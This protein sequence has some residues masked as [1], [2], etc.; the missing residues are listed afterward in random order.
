MR[1]IKIIKQ[2]LQFQ[3]APFG[4]LSKAHIDSIQCMCTNLCVCVCCTQGCVYVVCVCGVCVCLCVSVCLCSYESEKSPSDIIPKMLA[5]LLWG[6][7]SLRCPGNCQFKWGWVLSEHL[8][9][10]YLH[11]PQW[12]YK[13][14][15]WPP[16]FLHELWRCTVG[17]HDFAESF[18]LTEVSPQPS[19]SLHIDSI[20]SPR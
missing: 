6:T 12:D 1:N 4:F 14:G 18:F 19:Q 7:D 20:S 2:W 8:G 9:I 11:L 3:D 15:P 10:C 17:H 16:A 5:M 13:P